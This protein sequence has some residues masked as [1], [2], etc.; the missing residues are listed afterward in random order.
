MGCKNGGHVNLPLPGQW[1]RDTGQP[2]VKVRDNRLFLLVAYILENCQSAWLSRSTHRLITDL[3][4]EPCDEVTKDNGFI[5]L[6]VVVRRRD[7]GHV[8]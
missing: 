6:V 8:P 2:L 3:P 5:G 7:G 1:E 4:K